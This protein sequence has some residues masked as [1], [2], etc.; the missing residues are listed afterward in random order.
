MSRCP[1]PAK[2]RSGEGKGGWAGRLRDDDE[3]DKGNDDDDAYDE[4]ANT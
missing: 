2:E 3:E 1:R 4:D